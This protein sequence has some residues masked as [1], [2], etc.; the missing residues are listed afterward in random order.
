MSP[1]YM[2]GWQEKYKDIEAEN[3]FISD[4]TSS[5]VVRVYPSLDARSDLKRKFKNAH[6]ESL[7][8]TAIKTGFMSSL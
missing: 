2:F 4:N 7:G 1:L 8:I 6:P 5:D 3:F